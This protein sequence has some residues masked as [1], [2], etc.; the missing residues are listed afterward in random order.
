MHETWRLIA[1][2]YDLTVCDQEIT[3]PK[4]VIKDAYGSGFYHGLKRFEST[5]QLTTD[6]ARNTLRQAKERYNCHADVDD[7]ICTVYFVGGI[8]RLLESKK[9]V[10]PP[11]IQAKIK[12][13][14]R[15][16]GVYFQQEMSRLLLELPGKERKKIPWI[17]PREPYLNTLLMGAWKQAKT[18][19]AAIS[20]G[21]TCHY[22][23][24]FAD[25]TR[26]VD[27]IL[28]SNHPDAPHHLVQIKS[29]RGTS[30]LFG[31]DEQEWPS[32]YRNLRQ[33]LTR[34][35]REFGGSDSGRFSPLMLV[36]SSKGVRNLSIR[37]ADL[38]L[39]MQSRLLLRQAA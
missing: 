3:C 5:G 2:E 11:S 14:V 26:G 6:S 10:S 12:K 31:C 9:E 15:I 32:Q 36:V 19:F 13:V 24:N 38:R 17:L 27:L 35:I 33:D 22:P 30:E 18:M 1:R 20:I 16:L 21:F 8:L 29:T 23:D 7:R 34:F 25:G 37:D 39:L 4:T 28:E